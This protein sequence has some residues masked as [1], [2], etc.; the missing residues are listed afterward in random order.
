VVDRLQG[1]SP[2][3]GTPRNGFAELV[4]IIDG[5]V[6]LQ[7][8][9]DRLLAGCLADGPK[10]AALARRAGRVKAVLADL[11]KRTGRLPPS[12]IVEEAHGLVRYHHEILAQTI[13]M[14]YRLDLGANWRAH[15]HFA[16]SL[17][18]PAV[19][20]RR[21]RHLLAGYAAAM[22]D[23]EGAGA[24]PQHTGHALRTPLTTIMGNASSLLQPEVAWEP[25]DEQRLLRGIVE[26]SQR[27]ARAIDNVLD[28]AAM[29]SG[30][31][32]PD[33][34]WCDPAALADAAVK[35]VCGV[36]LPVTLA[37]ADGLPQVWGDRRLL[38]RALANLV[39]NAVR[40]NA[41]GTPVAL[42]VSAHAATVEVSVADQ[43]SGLP[44][45][46]R[47][48]L[49]RAAGRHGLP[50]EI[51]TGMAAT[52]GLVAAHGG[53]VSCSSGPDGTTCLVILAVAGRPSDPPA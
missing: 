4:E 3:A 43:G 5:V 19:R 50:S 32:R 29:Q 17:G 40:H 45:R 25:D 46:V 51:G 22:G 24:L 18:E 35:A 34:A 52:F 9:I 21:L 26:E 38:T 53:T 23:T 36:P 44:A 48:A 10:D 2:S 7:P 41:A 31:L 49:V 47:E 28:L 20:L 16:E 14:A 37:A 30:S 39:D 13:E 15:A 6:G 8:E 33:F 42:T 27:L 11:V 1:S 12:P